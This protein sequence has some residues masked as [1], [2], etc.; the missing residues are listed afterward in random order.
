MR[1]VCNRAWFPSWK[2][3]SNDFLTTPAVNGACPAPLVPVYRAYNNGFAKGIDSNHRITS[4]HDGYLQTIAA[5]WHVAPQQ[6]ENVFSVRRGVAY[7]ANALAVGE[8][9]HAHDSTVRVSS[10]RVDGNISR[11]DKNVS[12]FRPYDCDLRREIGWAD[13]IVA[14]D[15]PSLTRIADHVTLWRR[16]IDGDANWR[17]DRCDHA[18]RAFAN[19]IVD[20]NNYDRR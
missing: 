1:K 17:F 5:G 8:E 20:G 15:G 4:N 16:R 9:F 3:E 11:R 18:F 6:A 12:I 19:I 10:F 13:V 14:N 2:F 7:Y